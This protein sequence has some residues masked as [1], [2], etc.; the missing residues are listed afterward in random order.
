[1]AAPPDP[2][3]HVMVLPFP[4]QGHVMPLMELSHRLVGHGIEV[5]FVNTEYNHDR[6]IKAMGAE[7][8]AVDPGGIHMVSLPDGMGPDG[9]RTDIATVG[10]GLPAAMLA[11][12]KDMIRSRKTKWVIADV[13]MCWVMELAATTGVRVALFST[14]S[15]AVFA[16]RLH[17]PKLIDDGVLDECANVK[18]NVTIQLSPKMPPI[19][20][21]ELPWVCLSSL[22]DRRRVIIQI[23]QKTH[24][25]IPLA[26]AIICNTFEQIESEELDLVPNALPV[27]PL[28][29]PAASRSAGQLWQEDSACLPWLD[30]QARG[31]VIYVAF[32]SFTVFDAARFLE[33]A[34]GLELTGRPFLWTVRTNFTTGIGEDWL[35]AFKRRVEGKGLVVGWAPQQRVLSH[36]SVAC[37]VSHCG[38]NSTMEG[39]RHGVPFLCWPYFA[40]QF[41]NQSYI[42]NVWG[43]GVKIHADE[44]G[45]VTKEEIKNKVAQLLG[46]EGIKARAAIWKDAACT[47]IAEGGSSDQN[48]LKLVKLLTE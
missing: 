11:P 38:W 22:P 29:A 13:S 28:E 40:D 35:D 45:V 9:D 14:F 37:F 36:P 1:M 17:V 39:L 3:P 21:A 34:D 42:C 18:R 19:E 8:G 30:A 4:A 23:L 43:T 33:L 26:A 25:M 5:D 6:A 24:P 41:C 48:L 20:A 47:S 15:A 10:R 32:G 7:R 12:L 16:L 31:S 44:R 2:Q 46:D 27:G